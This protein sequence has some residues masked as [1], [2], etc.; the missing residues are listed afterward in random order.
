V[1]FVAGGEAL[2]LMLSEAGSTAC[3]ARPHRVCRRQPL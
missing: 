2:L 3:G 1:C